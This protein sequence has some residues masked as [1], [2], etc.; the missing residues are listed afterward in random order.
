MNFFGNVM[1]IAAPIVTGYIAQGTGAFTNAFIVAAI[2]LVVGIL[3][4]IFILGRVEPIP[5]PA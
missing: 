2:V 3:A 4:Y 1:A 5:E